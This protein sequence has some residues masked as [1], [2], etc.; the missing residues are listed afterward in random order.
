MT[1]WIC[2]I[3]FLV[4]APCFGQLEVSANDRKVFRKALRQAIVEARREGKIRYLNDAGE[5]VEIEFTPRMARWMISATF[6]R[7]FIE[8]AMDIAAIQ[9]KANIGPGAE[10]AWGDGEFLKLLL[11]YLLQLLDWLFDQLEDTGADNAFSDP[12]AIP[13]SIDNFDRWNRA[14]NGDQSS[15]LVGKVVA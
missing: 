1:K 15:L 3:L 8:H 6:S 7:D 11:P 12:G 10:V 2:L 5:R 9:V 4:P 13:S 14:I